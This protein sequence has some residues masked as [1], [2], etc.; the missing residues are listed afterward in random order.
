[1]TCRQRTTKER[2]EHKK[3]RN[4]RNS[5]TASLNG[6]LSWLARD[7]E[8]EGPGVSKCSDIFLPARVVTTPRTNDSVNT[9]GSKDKYILSVVLPERVDITQFRKRTS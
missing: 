9:T 2:V 7:L 3:K 4:R 6:V 1:M 8:E 5:S